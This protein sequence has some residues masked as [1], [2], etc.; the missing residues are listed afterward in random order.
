MAHQTASPNQ[1]ETALGRLVTY[2]RDIP[3]GKVK[4]LYVSVPKDMSGGVLEVFAYNRGLPS[5]D[6]QVLNNPDKANGLQMGS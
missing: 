2:L 1:P 6:E 5:N 3:Q 4:V